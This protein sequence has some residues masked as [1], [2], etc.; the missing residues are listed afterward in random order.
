MSVSF[1]PVDEPLLLAAFTSFV[2]Y[3]YHRTTMNDVAVAAGMSRPAVYLRVRN[4]DELLRAVGRSLLEASVKRA[5]EAVANPSADAASRIEGV[6]LA[7]LD[8]IL[9]LA[10]RSEHAVELLA[11]HARADPEGSD[12]YTATIEGLAADALAERAPAERAEEIAATLTRCVMGLE[13]DM[14]TPDL[15]RARLRLLVELVVSGMP[16]PSATEDER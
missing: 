9:D 12:S 2:R 3:G 8:L 15:A 5:E 1:T 14:A 16:D 4:K 10:S 11:A 6:L 13:N 7:K